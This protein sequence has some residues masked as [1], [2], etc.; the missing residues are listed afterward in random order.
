MFKKTLLATAILSVAGF[1]NAATMVNY[2]LSTTVVSTDVTAVDVVAA[3]ADVV[4]S[5]EGLA[6]AGQI[7][8]IS[9]AAATDLAST[10][11]A[12]AAT[13]TALFFKNDVTV[14]SGDFVT[15]GFPGAKFDTTVSPSIV[16][17]AATTDGGSDDDDIDVTASSLSFIKYEGDTIVF[18]A[19]TS[20]PAD[21]VLMLNGVELLASSAT[22]ITPSFKATNTTIGDYAQGSAKKSILIKSELANAKVVPTT[23]AIDGVIDVANERKQFATTPLLDVLTLD[24]TTTTGITKLAISSLTWDITLTGDLTK[25][26]TD[27][28]L[29]LETGEGSVVASQAASTKVAA[30]LGSVLFKGVTAN[31]ARTFTINLPATAANRSVLTKQSFSASIAAN[32]TATTA[33]TDVSVITNAAVG[34]WSLNGSGDD[35]AFLP[36]GSAFSQSVTVTNTGTVE[37]EITIDLTSAG[38]T[39]TTT[40]VST[41]AAKSVTDISAEVRAYAAE[42]GVTGNARLNIVVNSPS[43][44]IEVKAVYY[45]KS[46]NDRAVM[47]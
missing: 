4:I 40:L 7:T 34:S 41:A 11:F 45:S 44:Q 37:G 36:F 18:G 46:D 10:V 23:G 29:K 2:E 16:L 42:K 39:H 12:S 30:D 14:Q 5:S 9:Q 28:D 33:K 21:S 13:T 1:A 22:S 6:G 3:T 8:H 31:A 25:L 20:Q 47:Y 38:S 35:V 26:D 17:L 24:T 19:T 43:T 32:Y 15:I 27:G